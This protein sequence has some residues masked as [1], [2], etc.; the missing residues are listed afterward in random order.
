LKGTIA[1]QSERGAGAAFTIRLPMTLALTRVVLVKAGPE[2]LAI[3]MTAVS[4]ILRIEP[5]QLEHIG[6]KPVLRLG[7]KV[8]PLAHLGEALG[9]KETGDSRVMRLKVV[10]I[11]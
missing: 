9:M 1:L 3:P 6:R 8:V 7:G 10:V 4:Q 5:E 11:Q 2:T